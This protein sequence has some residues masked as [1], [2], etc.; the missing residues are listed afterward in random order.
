MPTRVYLDHAATSVL[1]PAVRD[2]V[3]DLLDRTAGNPSSLHGTGRGARRVVEEAREQVADAVGSAATEVV[4]TSGGTEADN[5]AVKGIAFARRAA[6]SRR[7][8]VLVSAV[9]HHAVLDA[10][11][12]LATDGA[13]EVVELSVDATGRLDPAALAEAIAA[14]PYSVALVS[15]MAAN[16]EVGTLQPLADVVAICDAAGIPVHADAVQALGVLPLDFAASGL[17]AMSLTGHKAGGP[18]G[19]GAL[20]LRHDVAAVPVLHG[21][22]QQRDVRSGTLDA[23]GAGGFAAAAALAAAARTEHVARLTGLRARLVA[24]ARAAVPDLCVEG[25]TDPA[26]GLPGLA[27]LRFPGADADAVLFALDEAGIDVS[28]GS[29]CSAGVARGSH[30]LAAM[31]RGPLGEVPV[32]DG[33]RVSMGWPTT[34]ADVD[35]LVAAL[36]DAVALGR[37]AADADRALA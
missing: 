10:A 4:L 28:T 33:I 5:L 26:G 31:G 22:G 29:A 19:A 30:V 23:V 13:F 37:A 7:R 36:P 12:W 8:R 25:A 11:H 16:N 35:A 6:D 3:A 27:W 21:G 18:V 14:E 1:R 34:A 17:A 2:V 9:E 20:V 24:G 32:P 15:V